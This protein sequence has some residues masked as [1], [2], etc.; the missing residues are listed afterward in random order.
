M[1]SQGVRPL[2]VFSQRE[3][4][5]LPAKRQSAAPR[6]AFLQA[7]LCKGQRHLRPHL[8]HEARSDEGRLSAVAVFPAGNR[9]STA[10]DDL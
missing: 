8:G 9:V 3:S 1:Y 4:F 6:P 2:R 10:L 5:A 7:G